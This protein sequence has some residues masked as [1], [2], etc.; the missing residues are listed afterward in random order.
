MPADAHEHDKRPESLEHE[1][2]I[3][4]LH[5]TNNILCFTSMVEW[6][7][8]SNKK[9][10]IYTEQMPQDNTPGLYHDANTHHAGRIRHSTSSDLAGPNDTTSSSMT[11]HEN[12]PNKPCTQMFTSSITMRDRQTR[13]FTPTPPGY[14]NK[15]ETR[16]A[17]QIQRI[18]NT[19][20][21]E[22]YTKK[23][24]K[25]HT[26]TH[27]ATMVNGRKR[28]TIHDKNDY[29]PCPKRSHKRGSSQ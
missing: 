18:D 16:N 23:L 13:R 26:E 4:Y 25:N 1:N 24:R 12:R 17:E 6:Q 15:E 14:T 9:N 19:Q 11:G 28:C 10:R 5:T 2:I 21:Y 29:E 22:K 3:Q 20:N 7:K 8:E 27:I